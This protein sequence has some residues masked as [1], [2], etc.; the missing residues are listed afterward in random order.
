LLSARFKAQSDHELD[1]LSDEKLISYLRDA[2][3]AAAHEASRRALAILVYGHGA[4]VERRLLLRMPR[5]AVQDAAH[6]ALVRAIASAFDGTSEG[7]FRSWL[8]TITDRT[9]V[10]WFRRRDRRPTEIPLPS[11]HVGD[12]EIWGEEPAVASEAGAVELQLILD[13]I[14][15]ELS[16][17]HRRVMAVAPMATARVSL[18]ETVGIT[19][20][21][22]G[23]KYTEPRDSR[24]ETPGGGWDVPE[25]ASAHWTASKASRS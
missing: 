19:S 23:G 15:A 17:P 2:S 1:Q 7:E 6:D 16:P 22:F 10:D 11:E 18:R 9:A 24:W 25:R 21:S 5:W 3:G 4:N 14:V 12:E 8:N 20:L 13:D